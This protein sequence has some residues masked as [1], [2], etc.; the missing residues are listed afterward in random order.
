M[1]HPFLVVVPLLLHG[2]PSLRFGKVV[3]A[4]LAVLMVLVDL[5]VLVVTLKLVAATMEVLFRLSM[6]Y[7]YVHEFGVIS[8]AIPC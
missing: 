4:V 6:F 5:T 1:D 2:A 7:T 8:V 3:L